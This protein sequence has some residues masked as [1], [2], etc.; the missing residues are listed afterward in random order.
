MYVYCGH[1]LCVDM[2]SFTPGEDQFPESG[3]G[4]GTEG[5]TDFQ[6][7]PKTIQRRRT[8]SMLLKEA[9]L[10][11]KVK[12]SQKKGGSKKREK[13]PGRFTIAFNKMQQRKKR[14]E[15]KVSPE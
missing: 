13:A 1:V 6:A 15:K 9:N 10:A 4:N 3:G 12:R 5:G 2:S 14:D 8:P 7:A 11:Q